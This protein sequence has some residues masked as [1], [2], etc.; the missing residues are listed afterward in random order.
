MG[1]PLDLNLPII[2]RQLSTHK[3]HS[4]RRLLKPRSGQPV[5]SR[6]G[7]FSLT[8]LT[9]A[10][11]L[12]GTMAAVA[13]PQYLGQLRSNCQKQTAAAVNQV[14]THTMAYNDLYSTPAMGWDDLD[15]VATLM[16]INGAAAGAS[17]G[18]VITLP[19]CYYNLQ[20]DANATDY[21]FT[22]NSTNG[23]ATAFNVV[24]CLNVE[25][26]ASQIRLGDGTTS[27]TTD[28]LNCG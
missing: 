13:T 6:S 3:S 5:R 1:Q 28:Q 8:E 26:G 25:T 18:E 14:M 7:G 15:E 10:V 4:M 20:V 23:G 19:G 11:A 27:A 2:V 12:A 17:F 22:S 21:F 16:T 9:V 24:G